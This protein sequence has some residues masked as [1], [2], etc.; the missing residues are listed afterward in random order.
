MKEIGQEL[1]SSQY[2]THSLT[3][4]TFNQSLQKTAICG[5][6]SIKIVS[7]VNWKVIISICT[8]SNPFAVM[9]TLQQ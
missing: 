5:D 4:I 9:L 3:D 1:F 2:F 7:V 6:T 8:Q